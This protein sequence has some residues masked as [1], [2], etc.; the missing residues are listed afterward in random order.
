MT[1]CP[2]TSRRS[3]LKWGAGVS[4]ATLLSAAPGQAGAQTASVGLITGPPSDAF[5]TTIACGVNAVAMESIA[6]VQEYQPARFDA[7]E[8][9]A[10][11]QTALQNGHQAIL[12]APADRNAMIEPIRQ[13]TSAGAIVLT[14]DTIIDEPLAAA[15]VGSDNFLGGQ[16]AVWALAELTGGTATVYLSTTRP[17]IS[18]TDARQ[19]GFEAALG[20]YPGFAYLGSE[21]NDNDPSVARQQIS[22]VIQNQPGLTAIVATNLAGS[23]GAAQAVL[24]AGLAGSIAVIG[25]DASPELVDL[26]EAGAVSALIGQ[27]PYEMGSSAMRVAVDVVHSGAFPGNRQITT[28]FTVITA[29][30]LFDPI[31]QSILYVHNCA[32][33]PNLDSATPA[34]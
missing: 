33:I 2:E 22:S 21:L 25:F 4:A 30:N 6:I 17:G 1:F 13:A 8:Q 7:A 20:E 26:L 16:M 12:I 11:L 34:A 3:L 31:I 28:D 14:V 27:H 10:L 5:W 15:E 18:T 32:D 24:D 23:L 9:S 29:G 19:Q